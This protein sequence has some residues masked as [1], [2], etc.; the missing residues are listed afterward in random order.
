MASRVSTASCCQHGICMSSATFHFILASLVRVQFKIQILSFLT[1]LDPTAQ[2]LQSR[3]VA[4]ASSSSRIYCNAYTFVPC[5]RHS[6]SDCRVRR[7]LAVRRLFSLHAVQL[8]PTSRR[9]DLTCSDLTVLLAQTG[10]IH[11]FAFWP[12]FIWPIS[13]Y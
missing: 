12:S 7:A 2:V 10:L 5:W 6:S 13:S 3:S 4:L 1:V 8:G 11:H 9:Q